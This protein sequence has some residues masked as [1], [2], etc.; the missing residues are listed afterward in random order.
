MRVQPHLKKCFEGIY[1]LEFNNAKEIIGMASA[2]GECV[3][4]S[5]SIQPADAKV[6]IAILQ[7]TS[8]FYPVHFLY[9]YNKWAFFTKIFF[10]II[11]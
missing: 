2:E 10:I 8:F 6:T 1:T 4:L 5:S 11:E 7:I 3:K 9:E